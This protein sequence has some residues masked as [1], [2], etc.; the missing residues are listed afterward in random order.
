MSSIIDQPFGNNRPGTSRQPKG[1]RSVF[2]LKIEGNQIEGF[3]EFLELIY[4][5][6]IQV[7]QK[8]GTD[9]FFSSD[10]HRTSAGIRVGLT[11]YDVTLL[12]MKEW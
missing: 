1:K 7:K 8:N 10:P 6:H 3:I 12:S 5:N 11:L 4:E 2:H 9:L